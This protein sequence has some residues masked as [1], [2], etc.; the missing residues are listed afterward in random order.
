M[1]VLFFFVLLLS[2]FSF[3]CRP[4][5]NEHD[6]IFH[7]AFL[8]RL[9]FANPESS[10]TLIAATRYLAL[11]SD[12]CNSF[13]RSCTSAAP[14][15]TC[16]RVA[17]VAAWCDIVHDG[18]DIGNIGNISN[19]SDMCFISNVCDAL[20]SL[21]FA[22]SVSFLVLV[23][24]STQPVSL[25]SALVFSVAAVLSRSQPQCSGSRTSA[26]STRPFAL[27]FQQRNARQHSY[28]R[29]RSSF[30]SLSLSRV[31]SLLPR[32]NGGRFS[33]RAHASCTGKA[34][35]SSS[36]I[37]LCSSSG[38]FY[39]ALRSTNTHRTMQHRRAVARLTGRGKRPGLEP[40]VTELPSTPKIK[41]QSSITNPHS[42]TGHFH[43][44]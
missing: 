8:T 25:S 38:S 1:P 35:C 31:V 39:P 23:C 12:C 24:S 16:A 32:A 29:V 7:S 18:D 9:N 17:A 26:A 20:C 3:H 42:E 33:A 5:L 2:I 43:I 28:A 37:R 15:F 36:D 14:A 19:L 41:Q 34:V 13:S 21:C 22:S 4:P 27:A 44:K 30:P 10:H 40:S 6:K 11:R